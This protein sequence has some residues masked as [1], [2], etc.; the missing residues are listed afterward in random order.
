MSAT[1]ILEGIINFTI[2]VL[3]F[4]FFYNFY[5]F[6][7]FCFNSIGI[8]G[9]LFDFQFF[10][11]D[12]IA[13]FFIFLLL[14]STIYLCIILSLLFWIFIFWMIIKIFVPF[15]ILIPI[16]FIPFVIPIPLKNML[17]EFIPPFKLLTNRGILPLLEKL[18]FRFLFSQ[19]TIKNKFSTSF[20]DIYSFLYFEIKNSI[21]N[22]IDKIGIKQPEQPQKT[23]D[24]N[25][26]IKTIDDGTNNEEKAKKEFN[27]KNNQKILDLIN[28]E[29]EICMKSKQSL[30]TPNSSIFNSLKDLNNY[31]ECYSKSIKAYIEN[32][33]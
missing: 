14:L 10:G 20:T 2:K 27:N 31:S 12:L 8:F 17:L 21:G 4:W 28:E 23:P 33:I 29:L 19:E 22:I 26:K 6:I 11:S 5:I 1:V 30:T 25:Y 18:V 16:P 7:Q 24:E 13:L 32:K 3:S 15:I 9:I